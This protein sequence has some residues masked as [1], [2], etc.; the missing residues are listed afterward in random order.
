MKIEKKHLIQA[1]SRML[2]IVCAGGIMILGLRLLTKDDRFDKNP[3][4]LDIDQFN[5]IKPEMI[6]YSKVREFPVRRQNPMGIAVDENGN[7]YVS[8]ENSILKYD[9]NGNEIFSFSVDERVRCMTFSEDGLLYT[10]S[11][12]KVI[13]YNKNGV[14]IS[15]VLTLI[16]KAVITSVAVA[17][18]LIFIADA[19]NKLV[20]VYGIDGKI[21]Y[22][23]GHKDDNNG[24]P[25]FIVPSLYFDLAF[26]SYNKLWVVNPGKHELYQYT[27]DGELISTWRADTPDLKG[28][29][30][31]CNPIHI[32]IDANDNFITS[33]KGMVRIKKYSSSGVFSSVVAGSDSFD[34]D[35]ENLD[36]TVDANNR[37]LVLDSASS[38]VKIFENIQKQQ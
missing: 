21:R 14:Q 25:W 3:L 31:C 29:C 23:I 27:I 34:A 37:I 18:D 32:A 7:I 11:K 9:R 10:A 1:V 6:T 24:V 13:S 22:L 4:E 30:G 2:I 8:G 26:D 36:M 17:E 38:Y 35:S 15:R 12:N 33:E 20:H 5:Q 19:G 28:F 16:E